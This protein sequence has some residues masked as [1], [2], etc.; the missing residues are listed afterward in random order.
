LA[1]GGVGGL[2]EATTNPVGN[3]GHGI[4]LAARAGA[5]LSDM[6]FVQFHPTALRSMRRPLALVSEAV[7]GEGAVLVDERM[8]GYGRCAWSD[9]APRDIV[10]RAVAAEIRR[11]APSIWMH[12]LRLGQGSASVSDRQPALP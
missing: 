4:A 1:T 7:R 2:Y 10:A 9:L 8:P 11:P 12:A 5:V 3:F 6:E